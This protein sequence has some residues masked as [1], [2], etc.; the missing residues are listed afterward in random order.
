MLRQR[1][2][3]LRIPQE[4]HQRHGLRGGRQRHRRNRGVQGRRDPALGVGEIRPLVRRKLLFGSHRQRSPQLL[5]PPQQ[6]FAEGS[7]DVASTGPYVLRGERD[8]LRDDGRRRRHRHAARRPERRRAQARRRGADPTPHG[9]LEASARGRVGV[10]QRLQDADVAPGGCDAARRRAAVGRSASVGAALEQRLDHGPVAGGRGEEGGR[11]AVLVRG[12]HGCPLLQR[13]QHALQRPALR[14]NCQSM[15]Q[16]RPRRPGVQRLHKVPPRPAAVLHGACRDAAA[17]RS[18]CRAVEVQGLAPIAGRV[19]E[20]HALQ[21]HALCRRRDGVDGRPRG[22]EAT[23]Q[24]LEALGASDHGDQRPDH[25][26]QLLRAKVRGRE[27]HR[28]PIRLH[29]AVTVTSI[30]AEVR[31][32]TASR[33]MLQLPHGRRV[34]LLDVGNEIVEGPQTLRWA[35]QR[36]DAL[37]QTALHGKLRTRFL[38]REHEELLATP[39]QPVQRLV[40]CLC[41]RGCKSHPRIVPTWGNGHILKRDPDTAVVGKELHDVLGRAV[42]GHWSHPQPRR[43]RR[44]LG[45]C[46]AIRDAAYGPKAPLLGCE[47]RRVGDVVR[48]GS[49]LGRVDLVED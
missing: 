22:V 15:Y 4:T 9:F 3:H 7:V 45:Q 41:H 27:A 30:G 1:A 5:Q 13:L 47:Q 33:A 11:L 10:G 32:G 37:S 2:P 40:R 21:T 14:R 29:P 6:L 46:G 39:Y 31:K 44:L 36:L 28:G 20:F 16:L 8:H 48:V 17:H 43:H 34:A 18:G 38:E 25:A 24:I 26:P 23:G 19:P 12:V 49:L 35:T 42:A